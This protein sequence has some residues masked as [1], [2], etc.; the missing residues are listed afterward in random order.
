[1]TSDAGPEATNQPS[2]GH[3]PA[4]TP[5]PD[6]HEAEPTAQPAARRR[7]RDRVGD[8]PVLVGAAAVVIAAGA[9][10]GAGYAVGHDT[11][12]WPGGIRTRDLADVPPMPRLP[13][14]DELRGFREDR[15]PDGEGRRDRLE[16]RLDSDDPAPRRSAHPDGS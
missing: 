13:Q 4:Q 12:D 14:G 3:S 5:P 15:G 9:A 2:E 1:M 10:F 6:P 8:H 11:N 7:A 16:R